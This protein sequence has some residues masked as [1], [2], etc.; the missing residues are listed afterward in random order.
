MTVDG[1]ALG[2]EELTT[3]GKLKIT[4]VAEV[5]SEGRFSQGPWDDFTASRDERFSLEW[6]VNAFTFEPKTK[7]GPPREP[8]VAVDAPL[9]PSYWELLRV[10]TGIDVSRYNQYAGTVVFLLPNYSARIDEL[11]FHTRRPGPLV[12]CTPKEALERYGPL[13]SC[14]EVLD[15]IGVA[16]ESPEGHDDI[17]FLELAS[18]RNI[19]AG[20]NFYRLTGLA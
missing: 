17:A 7:A 3:G 5:E 15:I 18:C 20:A 4:D 12:E 10:W 11:R 13:P 14:G 2:I 8:Y 1:L 6:P 9:F 19:G 16:A